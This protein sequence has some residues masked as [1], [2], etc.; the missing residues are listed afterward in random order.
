MAENVLVSFDEEKLMNDILDQGIDELKK[1]NPHTKS[2][3]FN[4]KP[5]ISNVN[6]DPKNDLI[7]NKKLANLNYYSNGSSELYQKRSSD[8]ANEFESKFK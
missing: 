4:N 3:S 1:S 7:M 5:N 2:N 8:Y 6:Y